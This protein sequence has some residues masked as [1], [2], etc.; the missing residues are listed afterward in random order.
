MSDGDFSELTAMTNE[1]GGQQHFMRYVAPGL[2]ELALFYEDYLKETDK[3]GDY[4]FVPSYS[5]ENY[6]P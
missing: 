5:P 4:I 1:N 2:R 3:N 6:P